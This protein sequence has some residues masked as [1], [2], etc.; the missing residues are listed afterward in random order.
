[1]ALFET[2]CYGPGQLECVEERHGRAKCTKEGAQMHIL[3]Q[4]YENIPSVCFLSIEHV[5]TGLSRYVFLKCI[6]IVLFIYVIMAI[7]V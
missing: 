2:A 1:M 7:G 6:C 3:P 5:C 4:L